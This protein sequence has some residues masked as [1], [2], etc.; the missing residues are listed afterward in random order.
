MKSD[1]KEQRIAD[2][3]IESMDWGDYGIAKIEFR[4]MHLADVVVSADGSAI[5]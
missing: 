2:S 1:T 3:S 4:P 5:A